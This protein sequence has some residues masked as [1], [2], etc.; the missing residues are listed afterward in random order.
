MTSCCSYIDSIGSELS[1]GF[2][3]KA[4][5]KAMAMVMKY[6]IFEFGNQYLLQLLVTAMGTSAACMW[7][8]N[9]FLIDKK[10][11]HPS[12]LELHSLSRCFI[13]DVFE[14]WF[15]TSSRMSTT[16]AF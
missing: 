4:A 7:A 10:E 13:D 11:S 14:I 1:S 2:P 9:F 8:A 6:N 12:L 5:K 15:P 3:L 16:L